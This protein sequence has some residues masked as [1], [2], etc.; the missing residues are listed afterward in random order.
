[1]QDWDAAPGA[2]DWPKLVNFLRHVKKTGEIPP[3]H[4]SH[5]HLNE[6]KLVEVDGA[7]IDK[8]KGIFEGLKKAKQVQNDERI[9][10]GLVDGF[11]LYWNQVSRHCVISTLLP[12]IYP[13][14]T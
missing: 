9:V 4:Y 14:R 10:W 11:L 3:D 7:V 1:M 2:I 6:Q 8:W 5:D 12:T 13:N